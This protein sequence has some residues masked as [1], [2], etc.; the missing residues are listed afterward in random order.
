MGVSTWR[1]TKDA[2]SPPPHLSMRLIICPIPGVFVAIGHGEH[3]MAASFPAIEIPNEHIACTNGKEGAAAMQSERSKEGI[4]SAVTCGSGEPPSAFKQPIG[5]GPHIFTAIRVHAAPSA[6]ASIIPPFSPVQRKS[7]RHQPRH[8]CPGYI[9]SSSTPAP[10]TLLP[11]LYTSPVPNCSS[12][13]PSA[14]PLLQAPVKRSPEGRVNTQ[15]PWYLTR[16]P[17]QFTR[18]RK[19]IRSEGERKRGGVKA[20]SGAVGSRAPLTCPS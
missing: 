3:A 13:G 2:S 12:P 15:G 16:R 20:V 18:G 8:Q 9:P 1:C 7:R 19:E 5:P 14:L 10:H 6:M 11:H 17:T 4:G